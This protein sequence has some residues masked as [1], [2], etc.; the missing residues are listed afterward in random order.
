[1]L[2]VRRR[3]RYELAKSSS[4]LDLSFAD[5][6]VLLASNERFAPYASVVVQSLIEHASPDRT[7]DIVVL[8]NDISQTSAR[9]LIGQTEN[10]PFGNVGLDLLDAEAVLDGLKLPNRGR[11]RAAAHYRL[12]APELLPQVAKAVYLDADLV[13]LH[14]VAELFDVDLDGKFLAAVHDADTAGQYAG[15]DPVVKPYLEN[16]V[17]LEDPRSYFQSGVLVMDLERMRELKLSEEMVG[18][19][20]SRKWRWPDQDILNRM[21]QSKADDPRDSYVRL[22]PRWN[23]LHDWKRLRRSHI[24]A[25]APAEVQ[26]A[27]DKAGR[28]PFVVHYAGPDDR[29]WIY[30]KADRADLFWDAAS[31]SP[32]YDE[33]RRGLAASRRDPAALVLRLW[34]A[35]IYKIGMPAID[36][37]LPCGTRRRAWVLGLYERMGGR[38][39]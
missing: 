36:V 2:K 10:S 7:Y 1:M 22:D 15:Y 14:D 6:V 19:A 26:A 32:F 34:I 13:V 3:R 31:R 18:L 29:P 9:R 30:P 33:L 39:T 5:V 20:V 27:Y 37:L 38:C 35:F 8:T 24:V 4:E 12:L 16:E 23:V 25:Q 17:G 11:F 28:D 21:A